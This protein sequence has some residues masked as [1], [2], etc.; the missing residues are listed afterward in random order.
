MIHTSSYASVGLDYPLQL[1]QF[2]PLHNRW[3]RIAGDYPGDGT[4]QVKT[5]SVNGVAY[6]GFGYKKLNNAS[7]DDDFADDFWQFNE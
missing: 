6:V 5:A 7:T 3:M 1:W 2:D 4:S